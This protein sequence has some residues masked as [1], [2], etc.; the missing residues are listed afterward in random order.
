V[1][2]EGEVGPH[3]LRR[4]LVVRRGEGGRGRRGTYAGFG[5]A[6]EEEEKEDGEDDKFYVGTHT[7]PQ[8]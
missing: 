6:D 4:G 3:C 7:R 8:R 5:G 1:V 2:A